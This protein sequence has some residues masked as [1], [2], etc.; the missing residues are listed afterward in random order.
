TAAPR[1]LQWHKHLALL[2][3]LARSPKRA[4][5]REHLIGLLWGDKPEEN[6]RRSLS[7]AL[8]LLR[9][10]AGKSGITTDHGQVRLAPDAARLD[11]ERFEEAAGRQDWGAAAALVAGEFLEGFAVPGAP[12]FEHWLTAERSLWRERAVEALAR[13]AAALL[14]RGDAA[15]AAQ[16]DRGDR[17][18]GGAREDAAAR[19][20]GDA[21]APRR[22]V[23]GDGALGRSGP[24]R[25]VERAAGAGAWGAGGGPR[26]RRRTRGRFG[27]G[28]GARAG[29]GGALRRGGARRCGGAAA[30]RAERRT[31]RHRRGVPAAA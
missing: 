15:G 24:R 6:A 26:A 13:H 28:G 23:R 20:A 12:E 8:E 16:R 19:G 7:V 9:R 21:G 29:M 22:R 2:V 18:R 30:P 31:A 11:T 27:G 4:R 17:R 25:A 1:E 5:T 14:T 3:Y 10:F